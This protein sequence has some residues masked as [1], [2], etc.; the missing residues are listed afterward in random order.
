VNGRPADNPLSFPPAEKMTQMALSITQPMK[1][2][3]KNGYFRRQFQTFI[4]G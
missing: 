2:V 1:Y 3:L 4:L